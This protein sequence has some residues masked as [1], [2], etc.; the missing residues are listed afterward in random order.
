MWSE[1][2]ICSPVGIYVHIPFCQ[3]KCGYCDFPSVENG[4][5]Y[6]VRYID[7]LCQELAASKHCGIYVDTVFFGGGT[8]SLLSGEQLSAVLFAI[9]KNFRVFGTAEISLEANPGT[10]DRKKI[11]CWLDAGFNRVSVGVQSFND[12]LLRCC[13]RIHSGADALSAL[14]QL[15]QEGFKNI[16]VDLLSGLPGQTKWQLLD[17]VRAAIAC[18]VQHISLYSL[19]IEAGTKFSE[20][21]KNGKLS[22]PTDEQE[23]E[24]YDCA[25]RE[26][27]NCGFSRYEISNY[28]VTGSECRHNLKYWQYKPYLGF[29][30]SAAAFYDGVRTTNLSGVREYVEAV[31]KSSAAIAERSVV[32]KKAAM[33][34]YVFLGLRTTTGISLER[35]SGLFDES[36]K[37]I[38]ADAFAECYQKGW[39][40][41]R[42]GR[43]V[44]TASGLKF[45]NR[46]FAEFI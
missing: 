24:M 18:D 17:S 2:N 33:S 39:L 10:I 28:A 29:G 27:G 38:F 19:K 5:A 46:V 3:K 13:G 14:R 20:A 44:L 12:D 40:F 43:V 37:Y 32:E 34:E 4:G 35:F 45:G 36:F 9:K 21:L 16:N 8:P 6:F 41:E 23:D 22:L 25:V 42:D 1:K 11:N 26:L 7:A 30:A 15:R 31:E